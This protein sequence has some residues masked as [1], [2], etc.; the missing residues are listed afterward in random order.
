[1]TNMAHSPSNNTG[2]NSG[3]YVYHLQVE[4]GTPVVI[5]K[6]GSGGNIRELQCINYPAGFVLGYSTNSATGIIDI[7][8]TDMT[9]IQSSSINAIS[10]SGVDA[11]ISDNG[12]SITGSTVKKV[13]SGQ[14]RTY[15]SSGD[16]RR[17]AFFTSAWTATG[18]SGSA[19]IPLP[20]HTRVTGSGSE[21]SV[22]KATLVAYNK[23]KVQAFG[24]DATTGMTE[25]FSFTAPFSGVCVA[26]VGS[27]LV[28]A[29][30]PSLAVSGANRFWGRA[31]T[32]WGGGGRT[33][34][35]AT[36]VDYAGTESVAFPIMKGATYT[37]AATASANYRAA[38]YNCIC[39]NGDY[40]TETIQAPYN[41]NSG[42]TA[43]ASKSTSFT[44]TGDTVRRIYF[45]VDWSGWGYDGGSYTVNFA[46]SQGSVV[47]T[48][49]NRTSSGHNTQ[50]AQVYGVGY[51][52][53]PAGAT[54]TFSQT[55]SGSLGTG[56]NGQLQ[57]RDSGSF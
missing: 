29:G 45:R 16:M 35:D 10:R 30:S 27:C 9:I 44:N 57:C 37:V 46:S 8:G 33:A 32:G 56:G 53:I 25:S 5:S 22:D 23:G 49:G 11:T 28:A 52:D 40:K 54:A 24:T 7:L 41:Y 31:D 47:Y 13:F 17:G 6:T 34:S 42:W 43:G 50:A 20:T 2:S 36:I 18:L 51:V 19:T 1:M 15:L 12:L 3:V 48:G 21:W 39:Y 26:F 55:V 14:E 4:A 38:N